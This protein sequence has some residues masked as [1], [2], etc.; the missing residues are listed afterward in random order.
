MGIFSKPKQ[1]WS[2]TF[3]GIELVLI[4]FARIVSVLLVQYTFVLFGAERSLKFKECVFLSYAGMIRGAIA[5]GLAIKGGHYFSTETE[6]FYDF[7]VINVLAIVILST[8]LFGSFMPLVAKCLLDPPARASKA[9]DHKK[10]IGVQDVDNNDASFNEPVLDSPHFKNS[11]TDFSTP[12]EFHSLENKVTSDHED[13]DMKIS[14]ITNQDSAIDAQ[15]KRAGSIHDGKGGSKST[16]LL[17][18]DEHRVSPT[19]KSSKPLAGAGSMTGGGD[20]HEMKSVSSYSALLHP[21]EDP[22]EFD[23]P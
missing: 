4:V 3:I 22:S 13:F 14:G 21:N 7:V 5:L 15:G 11:G 10:Q 6:D 16:Q 12:K 2:V 19:A 9:H 8:L 23:A 18:G 20:I 1:Q 17:K